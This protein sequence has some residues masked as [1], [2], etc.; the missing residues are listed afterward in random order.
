MVAT[1][2][3]AEV[4]PVSQRLWT[5]EEYE[6]M[7]D[8]GLIGPEERTELIEG[9]IY[10]MA[11]QKSRGAVAIGLVQEALQ[12]AFGAG[13]HTRI[14]LPMLLGERSE[15][16]PDVAVVS[17]SP[18]DYL[19]RHPSMA[20]LVVEVSD[21]TLAFDRGIKSAL[22]ARAAIPEYWIVNVV[23]GQLEVHRDPGPDGYRLRMVL[24]RGD[25]VSP[26]ARPHSSIPIA[27]LLP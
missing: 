16:E 13:V 18:R 5:C 26:L 19:P 10:R 20:F 23:R 7:G 4:E 14:Q 15:P 6:R 2:T 22:Y 8:V 11:A 27:D 21:T 24:K 25:S 9:V 1:K 17:G 3:R 12:R